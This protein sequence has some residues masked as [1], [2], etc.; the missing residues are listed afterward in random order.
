MEDQKIIALYW[1]RSQEAIVQTQKKYASYC[2]QVA[3][4]I[5]RSRQD[6]DEC[7]NDTWLRAWNAIPPQRPVQLRAYLAKLTRNL[8][9]D[10]LDQRQAQKRG[11]PMG[12]LLSEL[13]ECIPS[14]DTVEGTLD[15]RQIAEAISAW[16]REQPE[17]SRIAFVRR[18]FYADSLSQIARRVGLSEGGVKSLMH[19][20]RGSLRNYLEQEGIEV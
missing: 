20:Q 1:D 8:S 3:Y 14:P 6:A 9:L 16:L 2:H 12:V 19:R 7:V 11:G 17:R 15:N 10:R 5:L 4:Q 18:Y 13:S